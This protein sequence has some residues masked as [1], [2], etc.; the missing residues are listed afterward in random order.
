MDT[1][2]FAPDVCNH[3]LLFGTVS[4]TLT[5]RAESNWTE[6]VTTPY[7]SGLSLL[8]SLKK[9]VYLALESN[10]PLLFGTVSP[11]QGVLG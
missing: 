11:T 3:P 4:P 2:V 10:H 1:W 5:L 7:C 8:Q 9:V 6:L